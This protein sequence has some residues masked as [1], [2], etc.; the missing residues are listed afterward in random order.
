MK[1]FGDLFSLM[2]H[3]C[4][5]TNSFKP[6]FCKLRIIFLLLM[7]IIMMTSVGL[8]KTSVFSCRLIVADTLNLPFPCH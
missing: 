8:G 3:L 2:N 7:M 6:V 4:T 5:L 1:Y